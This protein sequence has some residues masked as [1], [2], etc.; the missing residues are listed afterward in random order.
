MTL[1]TPRILIL[2]TCGLLMVGVLA[3]AVGGLQAMSKSPVV[4]V[5]SAPGGPRKNASPVTPAPPPEV[6]V[7]LPDGLQAGSAVR[8][9][10][11][12]RD[13]SNTPVKGGTLRFTWFSPV[14]S[15]EGSS[16]DV[17]IAHHGL[18]YL[19]FR[20]PVDGRVEIRV[21]DGKGAA[22]TSFRVTDNS[23]LSRQLIQLSHHFD[24]APR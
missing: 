1:S 2:L 3:A 5:D 9:E 6:R 24:V 17:T 23:R 20:V 10:T 13:D 7:D 11:T 14:G 12:I 19:N 21:L 16:R 15:L 22:S 8:L 4:I 18:Y